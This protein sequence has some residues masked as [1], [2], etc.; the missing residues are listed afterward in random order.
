MFTSIYTLLVSAI[1]RIRTVYYIISITAFA[2]EIVYQIFCLAKQEGSCCSVHTQLCSF[3]SALHSSLSFSV[4]GVVEDRKKWAGGLL[5]Q[6]KSIAELFPTIHPS[7]K[8][9]ADLGTRSWFYVD[10][11]YNLVHSMSDKYC[12]FTSECYPWVK[13]NCPWETYACV[14]SYPLHVCLLKILPSLNEDQKFIKKEYK[15][16]KELILLTELFVVLSAFFP[17]PD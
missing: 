2:C 3:C 8:N 16:I 5:L 14:L 15:I 17:S 9:G 6:Q 12:P 4:G 11:L 10:S 1:R 13:D 7:P